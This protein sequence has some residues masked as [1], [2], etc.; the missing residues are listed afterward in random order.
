MRTPRTLPE[1]EQFEAVAQAYGGE[2]LPVFLD[3][4]KLQLIQRISNP[5]RVE[6]RK[7]ASEQGLNKFLAHYTIGPVPRANCLMLS[8]DVRTADENAQHI[9][10]HFK[11]L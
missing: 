5:D 9:A 6:R 1:F 8:S 4:S 11:L 3:C 2:L 10:I 7:T